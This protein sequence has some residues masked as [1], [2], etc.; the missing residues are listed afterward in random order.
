MVCRIVL[1]QVKCDI[2]PR[3]FY[4]AAGVTQR[5]TC[6]SE[7]TAIKSMLDKRTLVE[8]PVQGSQFARPL[9]ALVPVGAVYL[10]VVQCLLHTLV[11]KVGK[12]FA[13]TTGARLFILFDYFQ[14]GFTE[15]LA[16]ACGLVGFPQDMK[17]DGTLCYEDFRRRLHKFAFKTSHLQP[18]HSALSS[19]CMVRVVRYTTV[20]HV[21]GKDR[22]VLYT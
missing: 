17:T 22:Q 8:V 3:K 13:L 15:V 6:D 1:T 4:L 7:L 9:T 16:T 11:F 20:K 2:F 5:A 10:H 21:Y 18:E 14:A 12:A 19:T